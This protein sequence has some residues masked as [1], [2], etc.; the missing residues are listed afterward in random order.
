MR[1]LTIKEEAILRMIQSATS[2]VV[3]DDAETS[4][5]EDMASC[6]RICIII[7]SDTPDYSEGEI[8]VTELGKLALRILPSLKV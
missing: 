2:I 4:F 5:L 6:K 7:H 8:E 1:V 3:F